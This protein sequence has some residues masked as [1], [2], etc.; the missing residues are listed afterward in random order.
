MPSYLSSQT[1]QACAEEENDVQF[2]RGLQPGRNSSFL[3]VP[4]ATFVAMHDRQERGYG[5]EIGRRFNV[6]CRRDMDP[7]PQ[8]ADPDVTDVHEYLIWRA[9]RFLA[10]VSTMPL[11]RLK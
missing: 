10:L 8:L 1:Q 5:E 6:S 3:Y 9:G 11:W 4:W 2:E 7:K